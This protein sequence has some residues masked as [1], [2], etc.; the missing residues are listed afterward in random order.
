MKLQL[1]GGG[2]LAVAGVAVLG[3]G[4][5]WVYS[6]RGAV[7]AAAGAAAGAVA[8]AVNPASPTNLVNRAVSAAGEAA[9]G[10][11]GWSLGGQLAEWFSPSVRAANDSLRPTYTNQL[12]QASYDESARL[13]RRYPAPMTVLEIITY[14]PPASEVAGYYAP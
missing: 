13:A 2:V 6:K 5:W 7:A 1:S 9:T 12:P 14:D 8:D 10:Q 11:E 3:L 4:A